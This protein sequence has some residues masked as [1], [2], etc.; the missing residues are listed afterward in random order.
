MKCV[1]C[2]FLSAF[3]ILV[4]FE[5]L[6]LMHACAATVYICSDCLH[7]CFCVFTRMSW[8][9]HARE[10]IK[11]N[12][13]RFSPSVNYF[14][15]HSKDDVGF[16]RVFSMYSLQLQVSILLP[17][18]ASFDFS[19]NL[20]NRGQCVPCRVPV[21]CPL[22][23]DWPLVHTTR[24]HI[25]RIGGF[26]KFKNKTNATRTSS[27]SWRADLFAAVWRLCECSTLAIM[28]K[29]CVYHLFSRYLKHV[30]PEEPGVMRYFG[31]PWAIE[32]VEK[33]CN[34]W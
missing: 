15:M 21:G 9:I 6:R 8:P 11:E 24:K 17:A 16:S 19:Q 12:C 33:D 30:F 7:K 10:S 14:A 22:L 32:S 20:K 13:F 23:V 4:R 28:A 27:V 2:I 34:V 5:C 26:A 3:Q 31:R 18:S 25:L 1:S 29:V